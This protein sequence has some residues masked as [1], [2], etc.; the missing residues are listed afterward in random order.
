MKRRP[1]KA[2]REQIR[3]IPRWL[4]IPCGKIISSRNPPSLCG[5]PGLVYQIEHPKQMLMPWGAPYIKMPLCPE[6]RDIAF[7]HGMKIKLCSGLNQFSTAV[8]RKE[9]RASHAQESAA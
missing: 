2:L 5:E 8:A 7:T 6:H 1:T 3:K 4:R 9:P